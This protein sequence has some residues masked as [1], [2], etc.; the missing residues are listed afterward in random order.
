MATHL[1]VDPGLLEEI[2]AARA[3][4]SAGDPDAFD[5]ALAKSWSV[6]VGNPQPGAMRDRDFVLFT[7]AM[8]TL[9]LERR[10]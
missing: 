3:A 2:E 5:R 4:L 1:T 7:V 9:E 8:L 6:V 10:P